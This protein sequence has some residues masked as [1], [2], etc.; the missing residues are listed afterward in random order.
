MS[1][2]RATEE[3]TSKFAGRFGDAAGGHFRDANGLRLSS[4]GIG[5]YFGNWD[6]AT[7]R[8][9]TE[10]IEA[11]V[12]AGGNVI[13]TAANYRFQRSER[14]IGAALEGLGSEFAREELFISTKGGYLPFDGEPVS[15]VEGYFEEE[16]V[17]KGLA[18]KD[19]LVGGSHCMSPDYLESQIEQSLRNM[20]VEAVDLFYVHNP[21][22]QLTAVDRYTFEAR[23]AKAF[24]RLEDLRGKG[25]IGAYGVA[26]W[27]GFRVSP[28]DRAYHSLEGFV[29]TAKQ[30]AGEDHGLRYVQLPFNLAMP[31][32]YL[33]PNQ[34]A[35]GRA[36]TLLQAA[37]DLGVTVM[38]S[39]SI[40]QGQ[41]AQNVPIYVRGVL[42]NQTTDA[43]TSIQFARSTPGI[44]TALVG[45]SSV[46]HVEENMNLVRFE[47]TDEDS[48]A[49]L[50][51]KDA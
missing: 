48:F 46:G 33:V 28:D 51:T 11:F 40:L 49:E 1:L 6:E 44:T 10:A 34:S 21:E 26:T 29:R 3:G 24:E 22:S 36:V 17:S 27:N 45:M 7:D 20:D 23:I 19:D 15:D 38:S 39:A 2:Q 5:T 50:F 32:A 12:Q 14:S 13:D 37:A 18:A 25:K 43:M 8:A 30:I 35:N 16:F 42:G 9:Y 41:L 47:P 31:E 4:I